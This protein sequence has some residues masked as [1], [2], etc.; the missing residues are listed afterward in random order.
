MVRVLGALLLLLA[1]VAHT[2]AEEACATTEDDATGL[3]QHRSKGSGASLQGMNVSGCDW[4][5]T[6]GPR[7]CADCHDDGTDGFKE[8]CGG[9]NW[10]KTCGPKGCDDC[11]DDGTPGFKACC[12]KP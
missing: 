10:T 3:M 7:G 4:V 8:C 1:S 11:V 2:I 5:S 9:C 6:C 12:P